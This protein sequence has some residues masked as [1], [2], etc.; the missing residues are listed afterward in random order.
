MS[1]YI[2]LAAI[3]ALP[4]VLGVLL[5]VNAS[6]LFFSVMAGELLAR[7]FG[8]EAESAIHAMLNSDVATEYAHLFILTLPVVL[9]AIVLKN[10]ISRSR[11]LINI[12][13]LVVTGIVYAAFAIPLLPAELQAKVQ[14]TPIGQD[15]ANSSAAVIGFI[16]LFQ[17][18]ILWLLNRGEE[19][20]RK[21][22]RK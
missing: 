6:H 21:R 17:L 15:F 13:P 1:E 22:K 4:I 2:V 18:V 12:F 11:A 14:A 10:S 8:E 7:Y 19:S 9:T 3:V 5:R 20:K 16:V